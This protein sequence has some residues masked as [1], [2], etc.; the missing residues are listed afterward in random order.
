MHSLSRLISNVMNLIS[1]Q[2]SKNALSSITYEG[3]LRNLFA[4]EESE[5][6]ASI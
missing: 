6:I 5:A 4:F 2:V 1:S 3:H